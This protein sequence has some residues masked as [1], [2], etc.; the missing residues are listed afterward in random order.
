MCAECALPSFVP[1]LV[2]CCRLVCENLG[3]ENTDGDMREASQ[4]ESISECFK[5][6]LLRTLGS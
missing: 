4:M 5:Y 2:P 6:V 3:F 1:T